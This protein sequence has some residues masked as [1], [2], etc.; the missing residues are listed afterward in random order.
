MAKNLCLVVSIFAVILNGCL[1]VLHQSSRRPF[2]QNGKFYF[3]PDVISFT[4]RGKKICHTWQAFFTPFFSV[5]LEAYFRANFLGVK[6]RRISLGNA[7]LPS[8]CAPIYI[9]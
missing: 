5:S 1:R 4:W 6:I 3:P 9:I 7:F 8:F 2:P